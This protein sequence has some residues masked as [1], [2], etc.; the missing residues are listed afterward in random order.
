MRNFGRT[1]RLLA[2]LALLVTVSWLLA[3]KTQGQ[4]LHWTVSEFQP[5]IREGG[6]ANGFA[7]LPTNLNFILVASDTGGLFSSTDRG[8]TWR[9]VDSLPCFRTLS[10]A[11]VPNDPGA[12]LVGGG[13]NNN[14]GNNG[15]GNNGGGNNGGGN[16]G[17]G[18][19]LAGSGGSG[20]SSSSGAAGSASAGSGSSNPCP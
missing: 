4:T 2:G 12:V 6:R 5:N 19:N 20:G 16:N 10:V 7:V 3:S 8:R 11:F 17:S 14:G 9:H 15:G 18:N 1:T 13:G